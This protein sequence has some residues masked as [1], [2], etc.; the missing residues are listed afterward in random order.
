MKVAGVVVTYNRKNE[1]IKNIQAIL[2]QIYVIDSYY[3]IDN[4]SSDNTE[5]F[6]REAGIL[7][8]SIV[9][10]VYL[11]ENIGGSGGFYTG[12]KMAYDDGFDYICLMD[13]DGRPADEHMMERLVSAADEIYANQ[14]MILLN[15]LVCSADG[16]T[17]SFGLRGKISTKEQ[18]KQHTNDKGLIE[19]VIN[20]FNGTLVSK[21]LINAI[22]LPNK[23]FFIKGDERDYYDRSL[24]AGAYVATVFASNYFHPILKRMECSFLGRTIS[25]STEAPWKEYYRA[26]NYTF[27]YKKNG[28]TWKYIRRNLRQIIWAMKYNPKKKQTVWMIIRGWHDGVKGILGPTIHP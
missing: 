28:K 15:S 6:L 1:L 10:Y 5:H 13:D 9:K 22:G 19:G 12:L 21:E 14:K 3:I 25:S 23:D 26:R 24:K 20:P 18:A 16:E 7:D 2:S 11:E 17:L 27:M 4:H 8:N